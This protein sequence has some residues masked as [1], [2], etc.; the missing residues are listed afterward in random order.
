MA[1][2]RRRKRVLVPP[3]R[4]KAS[5]QPQL[6]HVI[7]IMAHPVRAAALEFLNHARILG[8]ALQSF[9][10]IQHA[11]DSK[12]NHLSTSDLDYHL[13]ELKKAQLIEQM[14]NGNKTAG[15]LLTEKGLM[16][17]EKYLEMKH[18]H[19]EVPVL[20]PNVLENHVHERRIMALTYPVDEECHV[21]RIEVQ[22]RRE[23]SVT[24]RYL[25]DRAREVVEMKQPSK[26][27]KEKRQP[28]RGVGEKKTPS[29]KSPS[30]FS[31]LDSFR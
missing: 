28:P 14:A 10:G 23:E 29:R 4:P 17:V 27:V 9:S 2:V 16:L 1:V 31:S 12:K 26:P 18:I 11:I 6:D 30:G 7:L 13:K 22:P 15:Y 25:V 19:V 3:D 8:D 20:E 24:D 21:T 5:Y